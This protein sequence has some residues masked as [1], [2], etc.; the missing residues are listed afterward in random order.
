MIHVALAALGAALVVVCLPL[1][2]F[3][4][5]E[6]AEQQGWGLFNLLALPTWLACALGVVAMEL[7]SYA[8]HRAFHAAP[9]LWRFHQIQHSDLDMDCGTALR[10]HP[11]EPLIT[12]SISR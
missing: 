9:F 5:A 7:G 4:M 8:L 6:L 12:H 10:H 2:A 11:I 3:A 1:A